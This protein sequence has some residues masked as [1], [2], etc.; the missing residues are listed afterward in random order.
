ARAE[1]MG[2]P[3]DQIRKG[4]TSTAALQRMVNEHEVARVATFLVSELSSGVTGQTIN[5]DAGSI[6]N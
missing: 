1:A 2:V 5:V 4:F 6:M 3:Y